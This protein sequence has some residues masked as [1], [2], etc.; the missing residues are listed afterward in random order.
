MKLVYTFRDRADAGDRLAKLLTK[1][2]GSKCTLY[3]LPRGGVPVG[4]QISQML[5][6]PLEILIVKKIGTPGQEELALGAVTEGDPPTVYYNSP[7]LADLGISDESMRFL[8]EA[9]IEEIN[10][11]VEFYRNGERLTYDPGTIPIIV[12]DGIATGA[13]MKA[14]IKYFKN[15]G[16]GEV[17]VA[18]PVMT[19]E[20]EEELVS[21]GCT[22]F[23]AQTVKYMTSVGEFYRDFSEVEYSETKFMLEKAN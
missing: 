12:D 20:M 21:E 15:H 11:L 22:A 18:V 2:H 7:I 6:I 9:K 3:A 1:Y 4:F 19:R 8:L 13:T 23:S 17:V 5:G 10:G 16:A 14:A